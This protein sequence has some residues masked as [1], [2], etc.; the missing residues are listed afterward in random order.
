MH[1]PLVFAQHRAPRRRAHFR[2]SARGPHRDGG[3]GVQDAAPQIRRERW[4]GLISRRVSLAVARQPRLG[5][6]G[7]SPAPTMVTARRCLSLT[8][9]TI[10]SRMKKTTR[11]RRSRA[12]RIGS[13]AARS[14][15]AQAGRKGTYLYATPLPSRG[16]GP[17]VR[18]SARPLGARRE[19][20]RPVCPHVGRHRPSVTHDTIPLSSAWK[21]RGARRALPPTPLPSRPRGKGR[22]LGAWP[23]QA[24]TIGEPR[25]LACPHVGQHP[26]LPQPHARPHPLSHE[27]DDENEAIEQ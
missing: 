15:E 13:P 1:R 27:E 25:R 17:G 6:A 23:A 22:G 7:V 12:V 14:G 21:Q 19:R 26:P 2:V 9:D 18:S 24:T 8:H 11:M 4:K 16:K 5:S 10:P 3:G 20:R